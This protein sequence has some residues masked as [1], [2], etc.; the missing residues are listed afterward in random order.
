MHCSIKQLVLFAAVLL[1]PINSGAQVHGAAPFAAPRKKMTVAEAMKK[2]PELDK[3]LV[4]FGKKLA[5]A[6]VKLK[7]NPKDEKLKKGVVEAAYGYGHE[8]MTLQQ[9]TLPPPIQYRAA[10]GYYR[11]ALAVDP[12]HAPSL[13]EK[14]MI[15]DIYSGMPGGIPK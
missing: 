15:D 8:L 14:K 10:L 4:P 9:G 7:K 2:A 3:A 5:D 6:E 1:V 12:K 13:K 11:K